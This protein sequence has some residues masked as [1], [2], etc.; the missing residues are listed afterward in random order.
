M[1]SGSA[2]P[3]DS[4]VFGQTRHA[5]EHPEEF[6]FRLAAGQM[7]VGDHQTAFGHNGEGPFPYFH[8]QPGGAGANIISYYITKTRKRKRK[9]L[10]FGK[11]MPY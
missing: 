7:C 10:T 1:L 2:C 11:N 6:V 8:L 9:C 5:V 4:D 3:D